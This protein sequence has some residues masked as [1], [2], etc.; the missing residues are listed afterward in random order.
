MFAILKNAYVRLLL[1]IYFIV[2]I[3][4]LSI[5][6]FDQRASSKNLVDD[7]DKIIDSNSKDMIDWKFL[8]PKYYDEILLHKWSEPKHR[9]REKPE[10]KSGENGTAFTR[11]NSSD[12]ATQKL[13]HE[14]GYNFLATEMM[15]LHRSLPD[16]RCEE[17]KNLNYPQKLPN[18]SFILIF[19]NEAWS[20]ILRTLWTIIDHS[21]A[22]L[23]GEIILVDDAS[24]LA[25]LKRPIE[26]YIE[27]LPVSVN[28]VRTQKREGLIRA[29]LI[30]AEVAKVLLE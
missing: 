19:H 11:I 10:P 28:L 15:S 5:L 21:P 13:Q 17:C 8:T 9:I 30:G 3:C 20:L 26:D 4:L 7:H 6:N 22:E 18:V 1:G 27:L 12:S 16:Y 2:S 29:R 24:D 23:I 14:Y 25:V